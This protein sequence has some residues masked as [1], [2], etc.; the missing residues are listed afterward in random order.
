MRSMFSIG[1]LILAVLASGAAYAKDVTV[2]ILNRD[3]KTNVSNVFEPGLVR[4]NK[5]DTVKW[6][7]SSAMHNVA[8][9]EGGVPTG[10]SL[11]TSGFQNV[12]TYKFDKPGLYLYKCVPHFGLGM[13]GLVLVGGDATNLAAVKSVSLPMFAKQRLAPLLTQVE[14]VH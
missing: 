9:V 5:G 8:F 3:S 14:A 4:V 12:I 11:F 13:V 1:A 7:S 6:V 2:Q 10:V